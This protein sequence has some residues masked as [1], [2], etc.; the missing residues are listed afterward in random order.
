MAKSGSEQLRA[1]IKHG[2]ICT[3]QSRAGMKQGTAAP[4][5]HAGFERNGD[6]ERARQVY[7]QMQAAGLHFQQQQAA[8][9]PLAM[10]AESP[11]YPGYLEPFS[12]KLKQARPHEALSKGSAHGQTCFSASGVHV[13]RL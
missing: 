13:H 10:P 11:R 8:P 9:P 12:R 2:T 1:R 3:E 4:N 7:D 5:V 6:M